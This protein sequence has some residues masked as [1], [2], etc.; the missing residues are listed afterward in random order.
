MQMLKL[1]IVLPKFQHGKILPNVQICISYMMADKKSSLLRFLW[2]LGEM[3]L[4]MSSWNCYHS[5]RW[6]SV[7]IC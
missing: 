5:W 2:K 7:V 3:F 6:I 1:K 4:V